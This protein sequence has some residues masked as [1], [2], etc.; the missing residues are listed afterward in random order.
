MLVSELSYLLN[1][2]KN[3][4]EFPARCLVTA[5]ITPDDKVFLLVR[6]PNGTLVDEFQVPMDTNGVSDG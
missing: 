1:Q 2:G 4:E 6:E 5:T 3:T